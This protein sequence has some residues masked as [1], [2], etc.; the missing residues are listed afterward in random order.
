MNVIVNP[1]GDTVF[2]TPLKAGGQAEICKWVVSGTSMQ[3]TRKSSWRNVDVFYY[4][5]DNQI[6]AG[7]RATSG[8]DNHGKFGM[9]NLTIPDEIWHRIFTCATFLS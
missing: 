4:V 6:Y 5:N 7:G 1:A 8:F 3:C 9:V 2:L